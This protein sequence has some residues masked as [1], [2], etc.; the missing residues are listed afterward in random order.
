MKANIKI[1]S[2]LIALLLS[3]QFSNASNVTISVRTSIDTSYVPVDS[4]IIRNESNQSVLKLANLPQDIHTYYVN[5]SEANLVTAIISPT[6]SSNLSI[7]ISGNGFYLYGNNI[8]EVGDLQVVIH[9]LE[10][11]VMARY[12]LSPFA[13]NGKFFSL[14]QK[15]VYIVS[16]LQGDT[17][18]RF[19]VL[20][21]Q[22]ET[23]SDT[24][25]SGTSSMLTRSALPSFAYN[26]GDRISVYVSKGGQKSLVWYGRPVDGTSVLLAIH[27]NGSTFDMKQT[28]SEGAQI[29][30]ISFSGVAFYSGCYYASTFYP[31]GKI[32]DYFG[33]QY[34][35]DNDFTESGHNTDFLTKAAYHLMNILTPSQLQILIDLA[36][37]QD[38][39]FKQYAL[40]RMVLIK[41]FHR[42]LDNDLPAGTSSIDVDSVKSFS[43]KLYLIDGEISYQRALKFA[44]II[45]SLSE[46]QRDSLSHLGA[47][48]MQMW[49]MPDKPT[50]SIPRGMN[51][52]VMSNAS[53]LFSWYL[54]GVE[55]DIYFCPERQGTYFG[56]FFMKDAPAV[57]NPGY[58]IDMQATANKGAY[59]LDKILDSNQSAEIKKIY[60]MNA[61]A[62]E[63]I[64]N[65]RE[66]ISNELRK[67]ISGESVNKDSILSWSAKYGE[68]D[69]IYIHDMVSQF[70][71][72]GRTLTDEQKQSLIVLRDLADYPCKDNTVFM[73]SSEIKEPQIGSTDFLFK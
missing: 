10:G 21:Q 12:A 28:L 8:N 6:Q 11:K 42:Y 2:L 57:G 56:G 64:V 15:G 26:N 22:K 29:N 58:A 70:V 38:T 59:M 7:R 45:N 62:L 24:M 3:A 71:K 25:I 50:V 14:S 32:A 9:N 69:G 27:R 66:L 40:G 47:V 36:V 49:T 65:C 23:P 37:E 17:V 51:T 44:E 19:K 73:Y 4:I 72:V 1:K 68:Y 30:T 54:R 48:G 35:R 61:P 46:E 41:A 34:L 39:L 63:G 33:F 43:R 55:A 18:T 16:V 20:F 67:A 5:L 31:P 52:W 60:A 13:A 53:E